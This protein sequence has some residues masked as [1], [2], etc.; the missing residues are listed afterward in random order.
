MGMHQEIMTEGDRNSLKIYQERELLLVEKSR[1][2]LDDDEMEEGICVGHPHLVL[3]PLLLPHW[4]LL[5]LTPLN[6]ALLALAPLALLVPITFPLHA[7]LAIAF[8]SL[9]LT[10]LSLLTLACPTCPCLPCSP[11]LAQLSPTCPRSSHLFV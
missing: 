2:S 10:P 6:L 9:T 7:P 4:Y 1:K 3:P 8:A 11:P 5:T